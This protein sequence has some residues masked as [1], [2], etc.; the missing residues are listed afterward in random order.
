MTLHEE[1]CMNPVCSRKAQTNLEIFGRLVGSVCLT[2]ARR[3][4]IPASVTVS[5]PPVDGF[6]GGTDG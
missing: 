4:L 3:F 1:I 5:D 2:C 6:E